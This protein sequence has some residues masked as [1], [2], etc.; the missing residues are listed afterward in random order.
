MVSRADV[1]RRPPARPR[2]PEVAR[3][4]SVPTRLSGPALPLDP[5]HLRPPL[6]A[7]TSPQDF[8]DTPWHFMEL[9]RMFFPQ[10]A[11]TPHLDSIR[12]KP[13][14]RR[15]LLR[16]LW[17]SAPKPIELRRRY[18]TMMFWY[19]T[20]HNDKACWCDRSLGSSTLSN[21][22]RGAI[23]D[24]VLRLRKLTPTNA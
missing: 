3:A 15:D 6:L 17:I 14:S 24:L 7:P 22:A 9:A 20:R 19:T 4:P 16:N 2:E 13:A 1:P 21:A 10:G 8:G 23:L 18:A 11:V 12:Q 5:R